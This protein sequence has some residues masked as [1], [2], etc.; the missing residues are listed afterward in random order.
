MVKGTSKSVRGLTLLAGGVLNRGYKRNGSTSQH[1]VSQF[2]GLRDQNK[3]MLSCWT[4]TFLFGFSIPQIVTDNV[5]NRT[6][7]NMK[8]FNYHF[9]SDKVLGTSY[10]VN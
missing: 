9:L 1:I 6:N 5:M 8:L 3:H 10:V 7:T 2:H 4:I